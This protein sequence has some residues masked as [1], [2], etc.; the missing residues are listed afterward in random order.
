MKN[1]SAIL[2]Y[3][4]F[5]S[6]TYKLQICINDFVGFIYNDRE[7]YN[8]LQHFLIHKNKFCM[9]IKSDRKMWDRCLSMKKSIK[10]KSE[11]VKDTY[12]GIC[13]CG[14]GEFVTPILY[15]DYVI[16]VILCGEFRC[17]KNVSDY[18]IKRT[19]RSSGM[20]YSELID[21]YNLSTS[22]EIPDQ[23]LVKS[24]SGI[25]ADYLSATYSLQISSNKNAPEKKKQVTSTESYIL[26]H[27]LEYI[28][29]NFT[30]KIYVKNISD[31]CHCSDSYIN[32]IFKR[33]M[34]I[35]IKAYINKLRVDKAKLL[36]LNPNANISEVASEVGFDDPNYFSIVF[37]EICG[38]TPSKYKVKNYVNNT[39]ILNSNKEL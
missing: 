33:R 24:V 19:S 3:L 8:V 5:I 22:F 20:N 38:F 14:I 21:N 17:H 39:T 15:Q 26:S 32:H 6:E 11:K 18:L 13:Y 31:F 36:L 27:A 25:L 28:K 7:L 16:G 30:T 10:D 34:K 37:K 2:D 1:Y 23:K 9:Q 35:N 12:Y 4:N 29:L